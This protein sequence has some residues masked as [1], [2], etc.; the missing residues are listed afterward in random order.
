M[1]PGMCLATYILNGGKSANDL[2]GACGMVA[3]IVLTTYKG[4]DLF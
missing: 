2:T 4:D 3:L 1:S